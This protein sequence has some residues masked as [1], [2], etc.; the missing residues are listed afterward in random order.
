MY[1]SDALTESRMSGKGRQKNVTRQH[2]KKLFRSVSWLREK[3]GQLEFCSY[4]IKMGFTEVELKWKWFCGY[5][6]NLSI[7]MRVSTRVFS[8]CSAEGI[9]SV[10]LYQLPC[11]SFFPYLVEI[12]LVAIAYE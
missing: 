12:G 9:T 3:A 7:E 6:C 8:E 1:F 2:V 10:P 4:L 5:A 11:V